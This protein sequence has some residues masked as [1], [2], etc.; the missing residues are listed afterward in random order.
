MR[1]NWKCQSKTQT[2]LSKDTTKPSRRPRTSG[3]GITRRQRHP[4]KVAGLPAFKLAH[5]VDILFQLPEFMPV[6]G[7]NGWLDEQEDEEEDDK[8]PAA[9]GVNNI[10]SAM[11]DDRERPVGSKKAKQIKEKELKSS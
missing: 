10:G 9:R 11:G 6:L 5:C 4:P 7:D 8:K 2:H 3:L 1:W